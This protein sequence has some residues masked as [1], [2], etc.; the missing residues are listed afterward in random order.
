MEV[1]KNKKKVGGLLFILILIVC[2]MSSKTVQAASVT[3]IP[4]GRLDIVRKD[5][6]RIVLTTENMESLSIDDS[7]MK[8]KWVSSIPMFND[9]HSPGW[10]ISFKD[11]NRTNWSGDNVVLKFRNI[12]SIGNR[13]LNAQIKVTSVNYHKAVQWGWGLDGSS[14]G[15]F[16]IT[17]TGFLLCPAADNNGVT[18]EYTF[19][20]ADTGQTVNLPFFHGFEDIDGNHS[21]YGVNA[22]GY[23]LLNGYASDEIYV[24]E[25]S[26]VN[27]TT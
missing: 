18:C 25:S 7:C 5:K 20:W 14:F 16:A 2:L 11:A 26:K 8:K 12:G 15:I 19:T 1:L 22:E 3:I 13:Q 21:G 9:D 17:T 10:M 23:M 6:T 4:D 27:V 24:W